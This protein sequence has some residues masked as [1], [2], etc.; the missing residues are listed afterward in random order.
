[1]PFGDSVASPVVAQCKRC[2]SMLMEVARQLLRRPWNTA[3]K[4]AAMA[5]SRRD[6]LTKL[7]LHSFSFI[8]S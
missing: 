5:L 7:Y 8:A 2:V 4:K 1:M 6:V 3:R